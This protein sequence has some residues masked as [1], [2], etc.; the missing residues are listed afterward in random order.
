MTKYRDPGKSILVATIPG[1]ILP[2][3]F[4]N[5]FSLNTSATA[6]DI[7]PALDNPLELIGFIGSLIFVSPVFI[8]F[9][10][11]A[12]MIKSMHE[13]GWIVPVYDLLSPDVQSEFLMAIGLGINVLL[14]SVPVA[15]IRRPKSHLTLSS[16]FIKD[17]NAKT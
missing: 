10:T 16:S 9:V 7:L 11:L 6:K 12:A 4:W 14:W 5:L 15:L 17:K 2:I 3:L 13:Y 1:A 8:I